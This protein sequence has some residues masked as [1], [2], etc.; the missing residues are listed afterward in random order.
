VFRVVIVVVILVSVAVAYW[1]FFNQLLPLQK[2]AR[3][4]VARVS[5]MAAQVD[6][7]ER[8]WPP[9]QVEEI[10]TRYGAVHR[11]LFPDQAAFEQWLGQ[12]QA[13]AAA[14]ALGIQV[15]LAQGHAPTTFPT[16]LLVVPA[17][18]ALEIL[19][20][21]ADASGK[22]PYERVLLFGQQIAAHGRRADLA[23]LTVTG[24]AGSISHVLMVF[25][26]WAGDLGIEPP[27]TLAAQE[28]TP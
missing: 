3:S 4:T 16:N 28:D 14:L 19:P 18:I 6:Q 13:Q 26:L 11:E 7:L 5:S 8:R 2:Q 25:N 20:S 27:A 10:R 17:S 15:G 23:E 24:G 12:L 1:S 9:A 22:S 21:P